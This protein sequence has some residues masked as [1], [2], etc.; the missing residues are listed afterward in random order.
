MLE[1][2]TFGEHTHFKKNSELFVGYSE[3]ICTLVENHNGKAYEVHN[4][5]NNF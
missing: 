5:Y 1:D 4:L 2:H 3:I